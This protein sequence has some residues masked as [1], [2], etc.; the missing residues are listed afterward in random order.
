MLLTSILCG[1]TDGVDGGSRGGGSERCP[2]C[3]QEVCAWT[4]LVLAAL[5]MV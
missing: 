2:S 1:A 4:W 3:I 5:V